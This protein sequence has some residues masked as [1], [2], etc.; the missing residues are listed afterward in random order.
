MWPRQPGTFIQSRVS[1]YLD[2]KSSNVGI[3]EPVLQEVL[4]RGPCYVSRQPRA[5][6]MVVF[7]ACHI[8]ELIE[9][10]MVSTRLAECPNRI[11]RWSDG[12]ADSKNCWFAKECLVAP[13]RRADY[14]HDEAQNT[15]RRLIAQRCGVR[16]HCERRTSVPFSACN[17]TCLPKIDENTCKAA[18]PRLE[19]HAGGSRPRKQASNQTGQARYRGLQAISVADAIPVAVRLFAISLPRNCF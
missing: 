13:P 6:H 5:R 18:C 15:S 7:V 12:K 8:R 19:V 17:P 4:E 11:P 14:K 10:T 2:L 1:S 16:W 3:L 9:Y